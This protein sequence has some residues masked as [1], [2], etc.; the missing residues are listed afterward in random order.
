MPVACEVKKDL[1]A[2]DAK[3][4]SSQR[5]YFFI[6]LKAMPKIDFKTLFTPRNRGVSLN[7]ILFIVNLICYQILWAYLMVENIKD[8]QSIVERMFFFAFCAVFIY[9]P[10]RL[11]YVVEN[12]DRPPTRLIMLLSNS[13]IILRLFLA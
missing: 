13:P 2:K 12:K 4:E 6:R 9:F 7:V 10:P 3:K 11:F 5:L 8:H 1:T